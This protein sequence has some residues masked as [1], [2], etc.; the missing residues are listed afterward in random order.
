MRAALHSVFLGLCAATIDVTFMPYGS[1]CDREVT[2]INAVADARLADSRHF[3]RA[4]NPYRVSYCVYNFAPDPVWEDLV[5]ATLRA[6]SA[7]VEVQVLVDYRQLWE[8]HTWNGGLLQLRAAGLRYSPTHLGLNASEQLSLEL[9]G[10]NTTE[11]GGGLMHLKTRIFRWLDPDTG[12]ARTTVMSGSF[13]PERGAAPDYIFLNNDTLVELSEEPELATKYQQKYDA[14]L[15]NKPL[16]NAWNESTA[17]NV[18]FSP[19]TAGP[20]SVDRILQV[21]VGLGWVGLGWVGLGLGSV[22][23]GLGLG[24]ELGCAEVGN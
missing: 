11:R 23:F 15:A 5:N 20:Q 3:S 12:L 2:A 1:R 18:L 16:T 14:V 19:D 21:W 7:G 24:P 22:G 17:V 6:R 13:N 4:E 8:S 9:I 10:I